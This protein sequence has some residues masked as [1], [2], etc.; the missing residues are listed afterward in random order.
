MQ[1]AYNYFFPRTR[2]MAAEMNPYHPRNPA[3]IAARANARLPETAATQLQDGDRIN[4]QNPSIIDTDQITKFLNRSLSEIGQHAYKYRSYVIPALVAM[5]SMRSFSKIPYSLISFSLRSLSAPC[6]YSLKAIAKYAIYRKLPDVAEYI[7]RKN[8]HPSIDGYLTAITDNE[9]PWY[10]N[11]T[12]MQQ[13][14]L[15]ELINENEKLERR[16]TTSTFVHDFTQLFLAIKLYG[17]L[18]GS[19]LSVFSRSIRSE[20]PMLYSFCAYSPEKTA[21]L[22]KRI[23]RIINNRPYLKEIL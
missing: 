20:R 2:D 16:T 5:Y 21:R 1:A 23:Q 6:S 10:L 4:N 9:R 8:T 3:R 12:F 17:L 18:S 13:D 7:A 11:V 14:H 22:Y 15:P 19:V